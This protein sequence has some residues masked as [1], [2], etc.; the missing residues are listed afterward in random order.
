MSESRWVFSRDGKPTFYR[1]DDNIYSTKGSR[2][3]WVRDTW[4]H[5]SADGAAYYEAGKWVYSRDGKAAFYYD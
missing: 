5:S 4:W 3:Y 1:V 2:E